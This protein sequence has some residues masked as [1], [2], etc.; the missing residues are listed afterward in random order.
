MTYSAARHATL[1]DWIAHE[2]TPFSLDSPTAFNAAVDT[3]I[4]SLDDSV[5]LLGFG[6]ALHGGDELLVLRN[7]LFQRLVEAHGYRAIA[8]ESSF[9]RGPITNEYVLGRGPASYKEVQETGFSHGFGKFEANRELVEWMRHYNA[10]PAHPTKLQFYG[11][12]SPTEATDTDSPRQ[13][14]YVALDYLSSVD[15]ALGQE[16]RNRIDPL[17]GQD[18]AWENPAAILDPMQAIGRSPEATALRI[19]TEELISELHVRR[20]E[21][22]AKSDTRSYLEAVHY[23]VEARQLL[24]YHAELAQAS[25]QR[26]ARLLGIR[27]AMMADNLAYIVSREQGRG[28]ILVFAHNSHLKRRKVQWQ[29]GNETVIWCPA[30]SHLHEMF[31]RRYAV[32]GSAIGESPANGIGQPE[33]GTLEAR[34]TSAPG[35][36]RFIPTHQGQGLPVEEL[37]ALPIR[38]GSKKNGSYM[39]PLSAQSFADFDWFAVLDTATY[40][41]GGLPLEHWSAGSE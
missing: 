30:G 16:Y 5:E 38:S 19:E 29:W 34:L 12:D 31:G 22:V 15:E 37:A 27:D 23:A 33:A 32:I 13:T 35:P 26:Q 11:F 41:R 21:L 28:K 24:N 25:D 20:P 2:A 36:M 40:N 6:E 17:L 7:Q 14:L 1:D 8:I 3:M 4:A 39:E 9:P 10:D 18:A